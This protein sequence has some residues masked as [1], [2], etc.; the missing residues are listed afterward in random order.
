MPHERKRHLTSVI[1]HLARLSPLVGLLGHRQVGKTT[2]LEVISP[3]YV[4]L[5]EEDSLALAN[6]SPK[7]FLNAHK[8]L[9]TAI[10]ECQLCE[11]IFPALKERVRTDKRPGQFYLS[12]SVRFTSKKLIRESLTGRIMSMDLLPL[13]LSELDRG[14][15]PSSFLNLLETKSLS[16]IST[17]GLKAKEHVR[18]T[19]LIK[20]YAQ[21]GGL[22]GVC[23]IRNDKIRTQKTIN[24]LETI[25]NRDLRQ[26]HQ[27]TLTLPELMR[28]VR[29]LAR[30]DGDPIQYQ[31]L[32]RATGITPSTQKKLIF[33]LEA[34]FIIRHL[35][36]EGDF[37]ESAIFFEDQAEALILA[38]GDLSEERRWAGLI[39]R[40]LREQVYYRLGENAEFFQYR[41]RAGVIIPFAIRTP[42]GS[43]GF[44][45]VVGEVSR[46]HTAAA[47]SFLRKYANSK[48][49][50]VTG[51][52]LTKV[53][54]DRTLVIPAT[55][56]LFPEA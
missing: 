4:T 55:K 39:Y 21:A 36:I 15:L 51:A 46:T 23:F 53:I 38:R 6:A 9:G 34:T 19:S 41:T 27:T 11:K 47:Q 20:K 24:L 42:K 29:E 45:P 40:N 43:V 35:P 18:R 3:H 17:V 16:D 26:I 50:L 49:V 28:F 7:A 10:D 8:L 48:A 2:L 56:L 25:L 31:S 54:D 32:R 12:G 44:I 1:Q 13:T 14:R 37:R 30:H 5:D 22:P 33:A 52:N